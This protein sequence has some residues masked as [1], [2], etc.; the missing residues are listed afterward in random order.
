M[1]LFIAIAIYKEAPTEF[2]G[3]LISI[4][5]KLICPYSVTFIRGGGGTPKARNAL[6]ADFL[7]TDDTH[8][9]FIDS[10]QVYGPE[11]V[12]RLL[13][14]ELC[15]VGALYAKKQEKLAWVGKPEDD[16]PVI[17]SDGTC[18]MNRI[19]TGFLLIHRHVL[20][21]LWE[22]LFGSHG[23]M[24]TVAVPNRREVDMFSI[25]VYND[26]YF[27]EDWWFCQHC[28]ESGIP[29]YADMRNIVGHLGS[30]V[31]APQIISKK[32]DLT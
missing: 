14:S 7:A 24:D 3:S 29:V 27:T 31:P 22:K 2:Y 1:K 30:P 4:G 13:K 17:D 19:G 10:D 12:N 15:V 20:E 23:Y 8:L 5:G 26:E 11:N 9:L 16:P 28:R 25:G 18:R 6:V 21:T 32:S